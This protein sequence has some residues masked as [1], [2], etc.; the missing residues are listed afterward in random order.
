MNVSWKDSK[1]SIKYNNMAKIREATIDKQLADI[2]QVIKQ[3]KVTLEIVVSTNND[4]ANRS[5]HPRT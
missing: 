5:N 4:Y 2:R 1:K 3:N